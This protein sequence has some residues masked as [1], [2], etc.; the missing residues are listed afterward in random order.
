MATLP[1]E[2]DAGSL[3]DPNGSP[4]QTGKNN[5]ALT[6]YTPPTLEIGRWEI[7][8]LSPDTCAQADQLRQETYIAEALNISGAPINIFK[9]LGVHQ[10]DSS[11]LKNVAAIMASPSAP[12]SP[13]TGVNS[14]TGS[15]KS[16][17]T[18]PG[19]TSGSV[20]IGMDFGIKTFTNSPGSIYSPSKPKLTPIGA[21]YLTQA[22]TPQEFARRVRVETT[23]G[24][25]ELSGPPI[26]TGVGNGTIENITLGSGATE[27]TLIITAQGSPNQFSVVLSKPGGILDFGTATVGQQFNSTVINFMIAA[28]TTPFS[29]GDL[30]SIR[31]SFIWKRSGVFSLAQSPLAQ[32]LNFQTPVLVRA[33]RIVPTVF[34][35]SGSWE[36]LALDANPA[37]KESIENI[38]DAFFN[39]NRDR[40]Y[41]A[42]PLLLKV[43]YTPTDSNTDLSRFGLSMM[44]QYT[45]KAAFVTMVRLLG[46]PIVVGDIIEVIP[47]LQYDM[48]LR[49]VRKF[50][51]VVDTGWD[52]DGFSTSWRP[53]IYRFSA[54]QVL[55][56]QETR[57]IFG[58]L[59]T[60]KYILSDDLIVSDVGAQIDTLPLTMSE[61]ISRGSA[62]R[63]PEIGSDDSL[64]VLAVP[65]PS[66]A[67]AISEPITA[68]PVDKPQQAALIED[69]L[70]PGGQPYGEGFSLPAAADSTDGEYFRLYYAPE[71]QI[72]PRLYR[73]SSIKNRWIYQETDR[74]GKYSSHR[75]SV[76]GILESTTKQ[77][78]N[79]KSSIKSGGSIPD[80]S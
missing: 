23:D 47:E 60:Q 77:A 49:P 13:V 4:A 50:L 12:G 66:A 40:D 62:D 54:Q 42:E 45:F 37:P 6:T 44:D 41:A 73:F 7:S 53:T 75:P 17:Q 33:V 38:E 8:T 55:P 21:L 71:T 18:G 58:T 72:P 35:G 79:S 63:V 69:G 48:Q 3:N 43:Q 76:R 20:W 46:R 52:A 16:L 56:S 57:D 24:S 31:L 25:C 26:L 15:W 80:H 61:E 39:E 32:V 78:I 27:G 10:Q 70:P 65:K 67:P 29:A 68:A 30:F 9:L 59:D 5:P 51:E 64:S 36:V 22:N 74:R 34:S 2:D 19:V 1:C 11:S 28:G 14:G